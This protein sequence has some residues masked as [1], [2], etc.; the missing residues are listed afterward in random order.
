[1][2]NLE[3]TMKK[4]RTL[5]FLVGSLIFLTLIYI[6]IFLIQ[7]AHINQMTTEAIGEIDEIY[8]ADVSQQAAGRFETGM[9]LRLSQI[10]ALVNDVPSE[11]V[12]NENDLRTSVVSMARGRGFDH[13]AL[14]GEN[15][16]LE[17]LYGDEVSLEDEE[18]F[19]AAL[20]K[21]QETI[22]VG[23]SAA[24][25]D[26]AVMGV[27]VTYPIQGEEK[28]IALIAGIPIHYVTDTLLLDMDKSLAYYYVIRQDGS[29]VIRDTDVEEDN[30]FERVQALYEGV[31]NNNSEQYLEKLSQAMAEGRDYSGAFSSLDGEW[32]YFYGTN[33]PYSDWYLL[34]FMSYGK[35]N[36]TIDSLSEQWKYAAMTACVLILIVLMAVFAVYFNLTEQQMRKLEEARKIAE[37][38]SK[39]KS[40][41]LSNMS[42]DIRTPMNAIVGMTAIAASNLDNREQVEN[43]LKKIDLSSRHL[44]GLINDILDMSK[45]E[46]GK[47]I[48]NMEQISLRETVQGVVNIIQPQVNSKKQK[49]D[50]Y[51]YNII[52]EEVRC[53][54]L[55]LN[56][57]LINLLGNAVKFTPEEGK[58]ELTLYQEPSQ[59]GENYVCSHLLVKD[60]GMGMTPEFREKIF[61]SFAREDNAR[62]Q[63]TEG[64]GLGMAI[65][66]YIV[67]AMQGTIEIK[68][69]PGEGSQFHITIDMEKA[70]VSEEEMVLPDWNILVV[71][72][73]ELLCES[74][75]AELNTLGVKASFALSGEEAVKVAKERH[76]KG[77]DFKVILLDWRMPGMDGVETAKQLRSCMGD[78]LPIMMIS[79]YDW[80]GAM[81][82]AKKEGV[83]GF[84][85][86]PLFRSSL[87]YGLKKFAGDAALEETE[88][89]ES[90]VNFEG[91][92]IL[93]AEDNDL[94][95]EIA[96]ELLTPLGLEVERAENGQ[97]CV[98]KLS[99]S[100]PS[101]YD[102]II[103]DIRMPVMTGYEAAEAIRKLDRED[104][105]TIPIIAMS[106]DAFQDDVKKC[107]DVGMNAHVAKPIDMREVTRVLQTYI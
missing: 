95:W 97:I 49:F 9:E 25:E 51:I 87:Y 6:F 29:F 12:E 75:V 3:K 76:E 66:K 20:E 84:L 80:G 68:S 106:A 59:R 5:H 105:G 70:E 28:S 74:A 33:L 56:Q 103:M 78:E 32:R 43:S 7:T 57:I 98:D 37:Q 94:N 10:S 41:F 8:M 15:G 27:P 82:E 40:E 96:H 60:N 44:L 45:I 48:L 63:K 36:E 58:I 65:T 86:K 16:T 39:A 30:Y 92:H 100:T 24:G 69:A 22:T 4:N 17:M 61:E 73:D 1:M 19:Y 14:Y 64:A 42:H 85:A 83:N 55:R 62:I 89:E 77:E 35:I 99:A 102:A 107:L 21:G 104:A 67:D 13:L 50:V 11:T 26:L 52:K 2:P 93:L 31:E 46:S 101:F 23:R 72:D 18:A 53:D 34:M 71:D 81:E 88:T 79:A 90:T 54:G 38:S 91:K 47:M